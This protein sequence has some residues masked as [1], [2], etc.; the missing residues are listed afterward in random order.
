MAERIIIV[1]KN[2]T[3]IGAKD[4]DDI[5]EKDIYR[6]SALWLKNSKGRILLARRAY[7]KSHHPGFWGPATAGTV[8]EGES[9]EKNILREI[10]EELGI[11]GQTVTSERKL[12]SE[13][14]HSYFAQWF[15]MILDWSVDDFRVDEKEVAEIRWFSPHELQA[16]IQHHTDRFLPSVES[17]IMNAHRSDT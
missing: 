4:R 17:R 13:T 6:V 5:T 1:D 9:Y 15:T 10:E 8:A 2:D 14:K 3:V 16:A 12:F 7:D 11:T